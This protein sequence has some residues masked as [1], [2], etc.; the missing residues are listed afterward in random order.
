[1]II[2]TF[3][4]RIKCMFLRQRTDTELINTLLNNK[5]LFKTGLCSWITNAQHEKVNGKYL[6][7]RNEADRLRK[8]IETNRPAIIENTLNEDVAVHFR[9]WWARGSIK[10]RIEFLQSLL[11]KYENESK[12]LP[13]KDN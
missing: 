8:L 7:S 13:K 1:M 6:I 10:P 9:Y 3:L 2:N 12:S 4:A 11:K 5:Q